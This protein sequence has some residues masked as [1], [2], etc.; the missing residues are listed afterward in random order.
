MVRTPKAYDQLRLDWS[1]GWETLR[2]AASTHRVRVDSG[3]VLLED[4]RQNQP[5]VVRVYPQLPPEGPTSYRGQ[6][7]EIRWWFSTTLDTSF[8][9]ADP[10]R[11]I[12]FQVV[13]RPYETPLAPATPRSPQIGLRPRPEA[14]PPTLSVSPRAQEGPG[15]CPFC[16]D[17]LES[18]LRACP[19]CDTQHHSECFDLYGG[20]TILGCG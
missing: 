7:F 14:L 19:R 9:G 3:T 15:L 1:L 12:G 4:L 20:C 5:Q 10:E 13:P 8:W 6:L 16:R 2:G 17:T 11:E 18:D